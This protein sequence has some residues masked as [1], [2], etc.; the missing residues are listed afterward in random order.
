MVHAS[1]ISLD[2]IHGGAEKCFGALFFLSDKSIVP[3]GTYETMIVPDKEAK[4]KTIENGRGKD[5]HIMEEM[6]NADLPVDSYLGVLVVVLRRMLGIGHPND[7][8]LSF[9]AVNVDE[10]IKSQC[11]HK[12]H[13]QI[14]FF[15]DQGQWFYLIGTDHTLNTCDHYDEQLAYRNSI[16]HWVITN[17]GVVECH[18]FL[19]CSD[20]YE[21]FIPFTQG[22]THTLKIGNL[23][24]QTLADDFLLSIVRTVLESKPTAMHCNRKDYLRSNNIREYFIQ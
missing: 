24:I 5:T 14:H 21:K 6:N 7:L 15:C 2:Q 3:A 23:L 19:N 13:K 1:L 18:C 20:G 16:I 17:L 22:I 9:Y 10:D 4:S 11:N 12:P 8:T